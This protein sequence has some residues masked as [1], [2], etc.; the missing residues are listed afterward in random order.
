VSEGERIK[1][2]MEIRKG[3][4]DGADEKLLLV[5]GWKTRTG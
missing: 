2:L 5:G 4:E 1:I 3:G